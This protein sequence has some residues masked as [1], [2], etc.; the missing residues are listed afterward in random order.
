[1]QRY[2]SR[3]SRVRRSAGILLL[4]AGALSVA[5]VHSTSYADPPPTTVSIGSASIM[6][7]NA[8][9]TRSVRFAVTLSAPVSTTVTMSY[10][11]EADGSAHAAMPDVDFIA[12]TGTV[13]FT[14]LQKTGLTVTTKYVT[15]K[16]KPDLAVEGDETFRVR[17]SAPVGVDLGRDS[18]VGTIL[19]DDSVAGVTASVGDASIIEGNA[20][21]KNTAKLTVTLSEPASAPVTV[22][23]AAAGLSASSTGGDYKWGKPARLVFQQGEWQKT[24][25][26]S[27]YPDTTAEPDEDIFVSLFGTVPMAR[28][29]GRV[30]ISDDDGGG[31][32][33]SPAGATGLSAGYYTKC[34]VVQTGQVRCWGLHGLGDG[35]PDAAV[36]PV[37]VWGIDNAIAVTADPSCALLATGG[38]KC[39]GGNYLG[40]GSGDTSLVPVDVAWFND[41]TDITSGGGRVCA[42]R[43][44][45][46]AWCWGAGTQS[47]GTSHVAAWPNAVVGVADATEIAAGS[48]HTCALIAGGEVKCWGSNYYHELGDGQN[49][50]MSYSAV[51]V[52]G[53]GNAVAIDAAGAHT[54]AVL[55]TGEVKCWGYNSWPGAPDEYA[56]PPSTPT[57]V[58][59]ISDAV[60]IDVGAG[61]ACATRATGEIECWGYNAAGQLG[62]GTTTSTSTPVALTILDHITE[63]ALD[64]TTSCAIVA[65][66]EVKCWGEG[67]AAFG[68]SFKAAS[69]A[70]IIGFP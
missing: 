3:A 22:N 65:S 60:G 30:T 67:P 25:S 56:T 59:G 28:S 12:K 41:F 42:L 32:P 20:G 64:D 53:I 26:V 44:A 10:S 54:C 69:P 2:R 14:P 39:W 70:S 27:I 66:G 29:T 11:I 8:G 45:G 19:D 5:P 33:P 21:T 38:I 34:A 63:L 7:G 18:A 51:T 23:A 1:M 62:D 43:A 4:V 50:A 17:L 55:A 24:V 13:K 49:E 61:D 46:E 6:E 48:G 68:A 36:T 37:T 35:K 40:N 52:V 9:S 15:A 16:V 57:L 58:P 47:A 31:G